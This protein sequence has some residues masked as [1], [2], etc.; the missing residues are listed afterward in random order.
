MEYLNEK[1][2]K[3]RSEVWWEINILV[4]VIKI[5]PIHFLFRY[6]SLVSTLT[7]STC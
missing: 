2:M 1:K 5:F 4:F 6:Y 7:C 3:Y